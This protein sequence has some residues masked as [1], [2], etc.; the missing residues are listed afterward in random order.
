MSDW[1]TSIVNHI[2]ITC[3]VNNASRYHEMCAAILPGQGH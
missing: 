1:D 3:C 2:S